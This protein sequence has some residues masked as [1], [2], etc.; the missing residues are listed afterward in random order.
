MIALQSV[1]IVRMGLKHIDQVMVVENL[2]F[3]IPW[4]KNAFIE[5][6]TNNKFAIYIAAVLNGSV[7]GYAGMWKVIDE[8]HITNIAVH[9]EFRRSGIGSALMEGLLHIAANEGIESMTLE[10]RRGNLPAQ[11]LYRKYGF[12]LA[13]TRKGY[14]ADNGE[15]ALIMWRGRKNK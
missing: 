14:Y 10:V 4:S 13:G 1:S 5:E 6:I 3:T 8:G 7:V 15:D 2:S 12:E 9:P 11:A